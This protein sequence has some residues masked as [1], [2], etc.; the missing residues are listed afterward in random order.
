MKV[1]NRL[2]Q[3]NQSAIL[4]E[5]K[6][7]ASVGKRSRHINVRY[8]FIRDLVDRGLVEIKYC[9]TEGMVADFL[10]KPL[11]GSLFLRFKNRILGTKRE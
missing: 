8:F 5:E 3:D 9:P 11:Q 10:T 4:L 1:K 6:G 2:H 7:M